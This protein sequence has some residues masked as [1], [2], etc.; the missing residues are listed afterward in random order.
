MSV[1]RSARCGPST[2]IFD[3]S[4]LQDLNQ[5]PAGRIDPNAVALANLYPAPNSGIQ[6]YGVSPNLFEHRNQFDIRGDVNPNE[7]NQIF[8]RFSYS[9]DPIFIPGPFQGIAD[10]GGFQQGDQT[11]KSGQAV[12][13]YTHVFS[14]TTVNQVRAGFAH[15]HTTRFGP[16][17]NQTGIP[18]QYNIAGIPQV[19]E[20][21]GLPA[22]SIGNLQTLGSNN[23]LPSDE[24][25]QTEQITDDL[26]KVYGSHSFK[27]GV[28][29]QYVKFSTLQPA[30]S[31]GQFQYNGGFTD[32]PNR[33]DDDRRSRSVPASVARQRPS[34]AIHIRMDS[35]IQAVRMACT[36]QTS[37]RPTTRRC[38]SHRTSRTT[39]S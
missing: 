18:D 30:W 22:F 34:M 23:F 3:R 10:G 39:G 5:L 9:D 35:T 7:H 1:T 37:T 16:V 28:E 19:S 27:M 4:W 26:T 31:R 32:I 2:T 13:G 20:N 12:A 33:V 36:R 14:P 6:T 29:Y 24:V 15:L 38:T 25:S 11:A 8:V 21:G 17:G